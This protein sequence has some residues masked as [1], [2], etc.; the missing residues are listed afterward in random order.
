[1]KTIDKANGEILMIKLKYFDIDEFKCKCGC[2]L[3]IIDENLI[4]LLDEAREKSG[5][6][7]RINS[8]CR[9]RT[10]NAV[11]G[12]K[13]SSSHLF[14]K[15]VDIACVDSR[16]RF[17]MINALLDVGFNRIGIATNFIHVDN[18]PNKDEDVI[19]KY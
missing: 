4:R 15:A 13:P 17:L 10:H 14:G 12:G 19:W 1:M 6:P 5:V 18:D 11:V 9:C 2:G 7:F 3:N 16:N 8:A